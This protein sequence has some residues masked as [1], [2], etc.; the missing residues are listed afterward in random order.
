MEEGKRAEELSQS[1]KKN[2]FD[3]VCAAA[4][5]Y[6]EGLSEDKSTLAFGAGAVQSPSGD[7]T[8]SDRPGDNLDSAL[9][10]SS[11]N[12]ATRPTPPP[13]SPSVNL[14][15]KRRLVSPS[16]DCPSKK[17]RSGEAERD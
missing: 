5:A 17:S 10:F 15:K 8:T 16:T 11:G 1:A 4:A 2:F 14:S 12:L 3:R 13:R 6:S 7:I 9:S